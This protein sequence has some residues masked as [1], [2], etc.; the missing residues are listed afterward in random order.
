VLWD[1]HMDHEPLLTFEDVAVLEDDVL[2]LDDASGSVDRGGVLALRGANGAGK[3]TLL[4]VLAGGLRPTAG[5][6]RLAGRTPDDRDRHTRRM[7]AALIGPAMTQRD[8]TVREHLQFIAA[9]WGADVQ[10]AQKV[11]ASLLEELS[12]SA[13]GARFPHELSSGQ[14]QLFS[15][16]MT[17]ARPF[18]LLLLDEPEQR[19]DADRTGLLV[20]TVRRRVEA[21]AAVV[22]ATHSQRLET[23]LA[24]DSLTLVGE[25]QAA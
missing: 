5:T 15:L 24:D 9:T 8:L 12:L 4:R 21:G 18:D 7:L 17:L 3:T 20:D 6:V 23:A 11:A 14:T 25:E 13:L 10:H 1:E 22:M 2:M 19:L 16:A